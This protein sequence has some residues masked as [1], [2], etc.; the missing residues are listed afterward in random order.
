MIRGA[1]EGIS[2]Q[3]YRWELHFHTAET[4]PCGHIPAA[5]GIAA[6]KEQG[7]DGVVVTDHYAGYNFARFS[8]SW[9][10]KLDAWLAGSRAA[11]EEGARLGLTVLQGM[12]LRLDGAAPC[13]EPALDAL[14][15]TA[16]EY[17]VYG[18]Q[19]EQLRRHPAL[20]TLNERELA[21]LAGEL[22]WLV[23]QAHPCRPGMAFCPPALLEGAE[24]YNGNK[25]HQSHNEK[26]AA[27]CE[28]NGL[29][30]LSGS[31]FHEEEDLARGGV[32][33]E[34]KI[35]TAEEWLRALRAGRYCRIETP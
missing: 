16:N 10:Q 34:E 22:G 24:V 31:D 27:F 13:G 26:A 17:L 28:A 21:A 1:E 33:F 20:Y 23:A 8:G 29:I 25:R 15:G 30:G 3:A 4:S 12:E 11:M 32:A 5:Q 7:Y 18:V 2:L 14:R 35:H 19:E 9:E 6:Y